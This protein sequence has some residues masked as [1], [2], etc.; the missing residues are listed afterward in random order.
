MKFVLRISCVCW[1]LS[2]VLGT[3]Q[4]E[5]Y[6]RQTIDG[7]WVSVDATEQQ[8]MQKQQ[9]ERLQKSL[10]AHGI[11]FNI[12]YED[13]VNTTGIG[14][15]DATYGA[16]RQATFEAV[17]TYIASVLNH[18]SNLDITVSQSLNDSGS[19][20]LAS[21]GTWYRA[22]DGFN[23]GLAFTHLTSGSDPNTDF[24]DIHVQVNFGHSWNSELDD[25][26]GGEFDLFSVLLH[27]VTHGLGITSVISSDGSSQ[28]SSNDDAYTAYDKF[29]EDSTG[30][31][32]INEISF[33]FQGQLS[34]LT[35]G[36]SY[37]TGEDTVFVL[38]GN[39][40]LYTPSSFSGGSSIS[41]WD[42]SVGGSP[43]MHPAI[44]TGVKKREFITFEL[45]VLNDLGYTVIGAGADLSLSVSSPATANT[46][47]DIV[48]SV[49][50]SNAGISE[51]ANV[52]VAAPLPGNTTYVSDDSS[53]DYNSGTGDWTVAS[54]AA[55]DSVTLNI[56][57]QLNQVGTHIYQA[58]VSASDLAD[59]D[60]TPGNSS[61]SEDDEDSSTTYSGFALSGSMLYT[62]EDL[63]SDTFTVVL[64]GDPGGT[65]VVIRLTEDDGDDSEI[66][67]NGTA[68]PV[69]L[70]FTT[71]DWNSPQLVTVAGR[72]DTVIDGTQ[73]ITITAAVNSGPAAFQALAD[74]SLDVEN[75]DDGENIIVSVD[76]I[77]MNGSA[78]KQN[79]SSFT[80][81]V[82]GNASGTQSGDD[83]EVTIPLG[84]DGSGD[85]TLNF[86]YS[87]GSTTETINVSETL[88]PQGS[89]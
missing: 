22:L 16:D 89:G 55:G 19:G 36:D 20:T 33:D 62:A 23:P 5:T 4:A 45:Y 46:G 51:A 11:T 32:M 83:W 41:H 30:T 43:V 9:I 37:F 73:S 15:D 40:L 29:V 70:T 50:L 71:S 60:S 42:L 80:F 39:L 34:D 53:G 21:A 86:D 6:Y 81:S 26:S 61:G 63:S 75:A 66:S 49:T 54:L 64:H 31:R 24:D 76:Q 52:T 56:T 3:L 67:I 59:P 18:S 12:T 84:I 87:G 85:A 68:G 7:D 35:S 82:S 77:I 69:D 14:F 48:Y 28:F 27:E 72:D 1:L 47:S 65:P 57:H 17:L 88:V 38:G 13:V 2:A 79:V 8:A 44:A 58:E 25:P 74:Q 10:T 78:V